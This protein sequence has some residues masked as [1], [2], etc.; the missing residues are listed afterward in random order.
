M[1]LSRVVAKRVTLNCLNCEKKVLV[2]SVSEDVASLLH[3]VSMASSSS[4]GP[5]CIPA[6]IPGRFVVLLRERG[7]MV[8]N[9]LTDAVSSKN[10]KIKN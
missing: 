10:K 5:T 6:T 4:P 3:G 1:S 7:G 8:Q 2:I 9:S